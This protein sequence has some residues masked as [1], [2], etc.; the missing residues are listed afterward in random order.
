MRRSLIAVG[1]CG[2]LST[3]LAWSAGQKEQ[4]KQQGKKAA[5]R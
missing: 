1:I 2:V 5:E 3:T 4:P